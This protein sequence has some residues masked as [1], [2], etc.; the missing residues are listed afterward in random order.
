MQQTANWWDI[1]NCSAVEDAL[2]RSPFS[3][4]SVDDRTM[5]CGLAGQVGGG[6]VPTGLDGAYEKNLARGGLDVLCL[7]KKRWLESKAR[8]RAGSACCQAACWYLSV[9]HWAVDGVQ[10]RQGL[11]DVRGDASYLFEAIP[12]SGPS[13]QGLEHLRRGG[14]NHVCSCRLSAGWITS[15]APLEFLLAGQRARCD[16]EPRSRNCIGTVSRSLAE[17]CFLWNRSRLSSRCG[18]SLSFVKFFTVGKN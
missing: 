4:G 17:D 6:L 14:G 2:P 7:E 5:L 3:P 13:V 15:S 16:F 11:Q 18:I 1:L 8:V 12:T 9:H 10:S